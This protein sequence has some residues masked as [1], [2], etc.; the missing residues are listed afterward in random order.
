MITLIENQ[1]DKSLI[2]LLT[3]PISNDVLVLYNAKKKI[4]IITLTPKNSAMN[5]NI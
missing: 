5:K 2:L 3:C 1:V 4:S